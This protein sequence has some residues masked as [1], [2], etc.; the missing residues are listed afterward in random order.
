MIQYIRGT[1]TKGVIYT[2]RNKVGDIHKGGVKKVHNEDKLI[3][4]QLGEIKKIADFLK[5]DSLAYLTPEEFSIGV[6]EALRR[7]FGLC[8]G[9][10]TG[11]YP[12]AAFEANKKILE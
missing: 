8:L 3:A 9:C 5:V 6:N 7:D 11:K 4:R 2:L 10:T 1:T 12:V